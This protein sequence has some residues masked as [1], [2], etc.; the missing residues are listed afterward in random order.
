MQQ[1]LTAGRGA[2]FWWRVAAPLAILGLAYGLWMISDRLLY[3][4]PFDR[5]WFGWLVVIPLLA[6]APAV[7]GL[8]W[9]GLDSRRRML[10]AA[11]VA[12]V[13]GTV[14]GALLAAAVIG[15]R[16]GCLYG[17]RLSG[18]DI[19]FA[20]A[21]VGLVMGGGYATS[22][23]AAAVLM[24]DRHPWLGGL[25]GA[26]G[27]FAVLWIAAFAVLGTIGFVGICNRPTPI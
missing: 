12:V 15:D 16:T 27:G 22:G 6:A 25:A 1:V 20:A 10:A 13:V 19:A 17:S 7:A 9:H 4:G 14:A 8:A 18:A 21:V 23:L 24:R 2:G 11:V 3:I 26:F 5:A